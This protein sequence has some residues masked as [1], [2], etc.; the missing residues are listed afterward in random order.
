MI[1]GSN[2]D[3]EAEEKKGMVL[4]SNVCHDEE[5]EGGEEEKGGLTQSLYL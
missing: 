5:A 1:L 2:H 4:G 3:E